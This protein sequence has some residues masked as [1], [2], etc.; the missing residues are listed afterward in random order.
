[1]VIFIGTLISFSELCS[2][3][4]SKIEFGQPDNLMSSWLFK[5]CNVQRHWMQVYR[6]WE[7]GLRE[8]QSG[9]SFNARDLGRR[10]TMP[11]YEFHTGSANNASFA[12][13]W[14]VSTIGEM[15]IYRSL[16]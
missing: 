9:R 8:M 1:M 11:N 5:I 4:M 3:S 16:T 7:Y 14:I 15:L 13:I 10:Q 6:R 12:L 2:Y